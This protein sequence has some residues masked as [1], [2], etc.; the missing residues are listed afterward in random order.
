[1]P[2]GRRWHRLLSPPAPETGLQAPLPFLGE[3][4]NPPDWRLSAEVKVATISLVAAVVEVLCGRRPP[5]QLQLW[6][7][8]TV[9]DQVEQLCSPQQTRDWRLRSLRAQQP[10]EHTVEVT[11]HLAHTGHSR[12]AA[13]QLTWCQGRW[14]ITEWC[15]AP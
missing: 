7:S 1:M 11:V 14:M 8:P 4:A 3:P 9:A 2:Q 10:S 13:L 6:A 15:L 12:A 5:H